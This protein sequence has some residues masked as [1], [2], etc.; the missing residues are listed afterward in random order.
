VKAKT[1]SDL[2][3][4]KTALALQAAQEAAQ[5][6]ERALQMRRQAAQRNL[7]QTAVG[8]V[9]RLQAPQQADLRPPAPAPIAQ[10]RQRDEEAA[11]QEAISDSVDISS[12]LETDGDLSFRRS[13]VG[14]DVTQNLRKG[15]WTMQRQ[16]DLHG[17]R[18]DEAREAL[19]QFIRQA[20]KEGLRCIRVIHG[21]GLGSP[22]KVPILKDK[23]QRWL[24]QKSEVLAFVQAQPS[25]GGAGALVVLLQPVRY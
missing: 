7:F 19:G 8:K 11:Y 3:K 9:Q 16:I 25:Q 21:K 23:V 20:H 6:Q 2:Q 17:L 13:G 15:K 12:L 5:A 24:V 18:S 10:Q 4:I 22:G 1:L 14:H